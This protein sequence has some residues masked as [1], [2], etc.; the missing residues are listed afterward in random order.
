MLHGVSGRAEVEHA[1]AGW[2]S[3]ARVERSPSRRALWALGALASGLVLG[4]WLQPEPSWMF[5]ACALL[6]IVAGLTRGRP[7][8]AA[9][10][11]AITGLGAGWYTLRTACVDP[12]HLRVWAVAHGVSGEDDEL[13]GGVVGV[14][15]VE[16]VVLGAPARARR[17]HDPHGWSERG[18][19]AS[20]QVDLA[21]DRAG[22]E[23]D[24][25]LAP[26]SGRVR[27]MTQDERALALRPG[28]RVRMVGGLSPLSPP[29]NPGEADRRPALWQE[30]VAGRLRVGAEGLSPAREQGSGLRGWWVGLVGAVRSQS[31]ALL[32]SWFEPG[33]E[34]RTGGA[35]GSE[36]ARAVLAAVL[37]GQR[38]A[39]LEEV[40]GAWARVGLLHALVISGFHLVVFA[41]A[42][43]AAVRLLG[44]W[45]RAEPVMIGVAVGVF[46]VMVPCETPVVRAGLM[47]LGLLAG[48]AMGR[49][50][51][52]VSTLGWV[53]CALLLWRPADLWATGF[54]LSVGVTGALLW[55]SGR[56]QERWFGLWVHGVRG[57]IEPR[58]G[59]WARAVRRAMRRG[60]G[61]VASLVTGCTVAWAASAPLI[62][63]RLG[64][65]AAIGVVS[66]VVVLPVVTLVMW[67]GY[68]A[69]LVGW[70][71]T[72]VGAEASWLHGAGGVLAWLAGVALGAADTLEGWPGAWFSVGGLPW[73]WTPLATAPIVLWLWQGGRRWWR[74]GVGPALA[75]AA[76]VV[77]A[78]CAAGLGVRPTAGD[79]E[80]TGLFIPAG[81][82]VLVRSGGEALLVDCG[83]RAATLG[84]A[85]AA[86]T[87]REAVRDAGLWRVHTL[88]VTGASAQRAAGVA[89]AV[90]DLGV[91]AV[92][93]GPATAELVRQAPESPMAR[94]LTAAR[95]A[96]AVIGVLTP[97]EPVRVGAMEF[98]VIPDAR[99]GLVDL[100]L[101][102]V[103]GRP[104]AGGP[105]SLEAVGALAERRGRAV[106]AVV[107]SATGGAAD[108]R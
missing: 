18:G 5:A 46:L 3:R 60:K 64:V 28:D 8:A 85:A 50:Y 84:G 35:E 7:C 51:D 101:T 29:R 59:G 94:T 33:G 67:L 45:G 1:G 77:L 30:G 68:A 106:R 42:A 10:L 97:G 40:R 92:L 87:A 11:L 104:A 95:S 14:L 15:A 61:W 34:E 72:A 32:G 76:I 73:W 41:G 79:A 78:G 88:V 43:L 55:L 75:A 91:R 19:R 44:D 4:R 93:I 27:V 63:Q 81:R 38:E 108:S 82:S 70:L 47:V 80:V 39:G 17:A 23:A 71:V 103:A 48:E 107:V 52:R 20:L 37:L 83:T 90:R 65:F 99:G 24:A 56:A 22:A 36:A 21:V 6:L 96:G 49:R 57:V 9:L 54:Q 74:G 26:A 105:I 31:A 16:G 86:R 100:V 2:A 89:E 102:G 69:L 12:G 98:E 62:A 66:S 13:P 25:R 53:A 58:R